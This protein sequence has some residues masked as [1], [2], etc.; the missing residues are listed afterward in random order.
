[1]FKSAQPPS[2]QVPFEKRT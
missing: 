1:V 2:E